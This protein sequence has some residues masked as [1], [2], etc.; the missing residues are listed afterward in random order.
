[1][2]KAVLKIWLPSAA[3]TICEVD[4][5]EPLIALSFTD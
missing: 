1:V 4:V 3:S 5:F 2:E